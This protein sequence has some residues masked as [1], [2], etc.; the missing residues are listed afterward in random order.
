[1]G[2]GCYKGVT[3]NKLKRGMR[4]RHKR[5]GLTG[6]VDSAYEHRD[7]GGNPDI[8]V[9]VDGQDPDDDLLSDK[10]YEFEAI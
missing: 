5:L 9:L 4:V 10:E 3:D 2:F 1:M 6:T 7:D 8:D